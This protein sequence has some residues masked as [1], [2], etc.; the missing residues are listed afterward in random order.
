[1]RN[2]EGHRDVPK[3]NKG[4]EGTDFPWCLA[5]SPISLSYLWLKEHLH[6]LGDENLPRPREGDPQSSCD[7][8]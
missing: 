5:P 7:E 6:L 3:G 1:M 8:T 2:L 4:A